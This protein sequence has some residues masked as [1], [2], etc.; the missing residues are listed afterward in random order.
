MIFLSGFLLA[1]CGSA[2]VYAPV[3]NQYSSIKPSSTTHIV[4]RGDTL[5]SIAWQLR[6]DYREIA[7]W[8]NI[9]PPYTIYMGQKLTLIAAKH[10]PKKHTQTVN[11]K[12]KTLKKQQLAKKSSSNNK[13]TLKLSWAWPIKVRQ[14]EKDRANSGVTLIGSPGELV[15]SSESGKVVY[16]GNGL[17]GY[18]NL[19][20]IMHNEEFLTAYGYNKRLLVNEGSVVKK[21]QAIAEIGKDNKNRQ[22]LFFELRR[23][24]KAVTIS[25]YLPKYGR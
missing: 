20:I 19:L 15:R 2:K 25:Q 7:Q 9:R 14:V 3:S 17:K 10:H 4:R 13:K 8:N 11:K 23:H 21:G 22:I 6:R 1:S 18:G 16:A 24:G 12:T 5:Y